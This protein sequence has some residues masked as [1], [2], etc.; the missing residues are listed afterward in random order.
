MGGIC[1]QPKKKRN[2]A[3][4]PSSAQSWR[5]NLGLK[6]AQATLEKQC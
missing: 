1:F 4:L 6:E 3:A 5:S 2:D